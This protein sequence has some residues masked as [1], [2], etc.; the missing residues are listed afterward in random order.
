MIEVIPLKYG[1]AFKRVFSQPEVFTRFARS[2]YHLETFSLTVGNRTITYS[3]K[4]GI[5]CYQ[6]S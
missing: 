1:A 3:K 6:K 4:Y 5:P 2:R